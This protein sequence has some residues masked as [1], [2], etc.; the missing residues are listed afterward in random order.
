MIVM[1]ESKVRKSR[2]STTIGRNWKTRPSANS[3][4]VLDLV[5]HLGEILD[6]CGFYTDVIPTE[7]SFE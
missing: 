5:A 1:G 6:Q 3:I 2:Q 4:E 7:W